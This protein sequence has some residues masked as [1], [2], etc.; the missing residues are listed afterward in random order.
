MPGAQEKN[1]KAY[2]KV[3]TH[4]LKKTEQASEPDMVGMLELLDQELKRAKGSKGSHRY[5]AKTD[6]QSKQRDGVLR[7][8]QKKC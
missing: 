2:Q 3:K 4:I 8:N 5:C 6:G 7:K 1:D